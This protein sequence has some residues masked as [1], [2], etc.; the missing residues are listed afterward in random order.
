M[1]EYVATY[2]QE[3]SHT[4]K[5]SDTHNAGARA[6]E[7]ARQNKLVVLSVYRKDVVPVATLPDA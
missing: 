4:I 7:Y 2:A 5:A 1:N 3:I 6:K